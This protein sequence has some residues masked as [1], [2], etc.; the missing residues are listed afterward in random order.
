M[1]T[2]LLS[3]IAKANMWALD[4]NFS[5][6]RAGVA[7]DSQEGWGYLLCNTNDMHSPP[8]I[9]TVGRAFLKFDLSG[10][11]AGAIVAA[12]LLGNGRNWNYSEETETYG[13]SM[14]GYIKAS[15]YLGADPWTLDDFSNLGWDNFLYG[16][17]TV[18]NTG[19]G[20]A[21]FAMDLNALCISDIEGVRQGDGVFILGISCKGDWEAILPEYSVDPLTT[22]QQI[23]EAVRLELT[24]EGGGSPPGSVGSGCA[25]MIRLFPA[26]FV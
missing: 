7:V 22:D 23:I 13:W 10:V 8:D 17:P 6:C 3:P 25:P 2:V 12:R 16:G 26:T 9:Y 5:D 24:L 19:P 14:I 11:P 21:P 18:L 20:Q 1:S 4:D 15:K